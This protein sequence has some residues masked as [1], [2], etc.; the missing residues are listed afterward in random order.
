MTAQNS[1]TSMKEKPQAYG[2]FC[3]L[4]RDPFLESILARF[5]Q[6]SST[7]PEISRLVRKLSAGLLQAAVNSLFGMSDQTIKT[8]MLKFHA[9]AEFSQSLISRDQK[10][11][12][13]D[14]MR[15][16]ILPSQEIFEALHEILPATQIRQ[17]H[18][19]INRAVDQNERVTGVKLSGHKIGGSI[20][21]AYVFIP[22]P[23]GA[24]GGSLESV[25][26]LYE[27]LN[28]GVPR[29]FVALHFIVT[30]EF[31]KRMKPYAHQLEIF[32]LRVDRGLSPADVL[33]KVPGED[34]DRER[35]LNEK[36]YIVPGAGGIGELL[37]NSFV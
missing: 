13:V 36:Q 7:Q 34:W 24:T 12:V 25:M 33:A 2:R 22:D 20:Q 23:M 27:G 9:E 32:C 15:A 18:I 11:V 6:E 4:L 26:K 31:L 37:N 1:E 5:S 29:K 10:A 8:R 17:D 35:G 19:L 30:P 16:G 3:H 28:L 14:L 21:D